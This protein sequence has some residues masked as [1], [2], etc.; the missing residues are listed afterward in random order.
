MNLHPSTSHSG[1][2]RTS[3]K[4][5][6]GSASLVSLSACATSFPNRVTISLQKSHFLR[7]LRA[8]LD[9]LLRRAKS[10]ELFQFS[11]LCS[12]SSNITDR[13]SALLFAFTAIFLIS[14]GVLGP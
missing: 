7:P 5:R 10:F 9:L 6:S 1:H 14:R 8:E 4:L 2:L 3:V 12:Q 13:A 11:P